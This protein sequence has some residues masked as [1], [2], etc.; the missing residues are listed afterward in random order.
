MNFPKFY[1]TS[2]SPRWLISYP[3]GA[4][5][6]YWALYRCHFKRSVY[7]LLEKYRIGVLKKEDQV[8]FDT[9]EDPFCHEP[10]RHP[11]LATLRLGV[12][13]KIRLH[14]IAKEFYFF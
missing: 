6:Y 8:D 14:I 12:T 5:E 1:E 7:N 11:G 9:L 4:V 2:H 10:V 3:E 13:V